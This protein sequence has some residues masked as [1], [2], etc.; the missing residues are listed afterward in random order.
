VFLG[1]GN[2]GLQPSDQGASG[3]GVAGVGAFEG[4]L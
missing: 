4:A 2:G 1:A 3:C